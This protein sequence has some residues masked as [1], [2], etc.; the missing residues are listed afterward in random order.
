M[1]KEYYVIS[2]NK[3]YIK[4]I[5][6]IMLNDLKNSDK[7]ETPDKK[8]NHQKFDPTKSVEI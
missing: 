7:N 6:R 8:I 1:K 4:Q 3:K 5:S 2:S